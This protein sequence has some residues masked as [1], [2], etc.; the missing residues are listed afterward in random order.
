MIPSL[1]RHPRIRWRVFLLFFTAL[2]FQK[3]ISFAAHQ[4]IWLKNGQGERISPSRNSAEPYSP[5]R[6]C[7]TCHGYA[8]ITSGGHFRIGVLR[9]GAG[10]FLNRR[11][12]KTLQRISLLTPFSE[13]LASKR[14]V[15]SRTMGL[16]VY[17]W[18]GA[19]GK[20][21]PK[22][23][24]AAAAGGWYHPGGGILEFARKPDGSLDFSKPL[25]GA[26]TGKADRLDGDF[27]SRFTPDG[28]S[29]FQASGAV[30]AD[31]LICHDQDYR[32]K[33]RNTQLDRRNYR[34]A[35]TSG[36][37][38]GR[39]DGAVFNPIPLPTDAAGED[40]RKGR[41]NFET[42]PGVSYEWSDRARFT[43]EG[44]LKGKVIS[45]AVSARN[46]LQCHGEMAA[47]NMGTIF[48]AGNDV[49]V[50]AGFRCTDCHGLE[51]KTKAERLRHRFAGEEARRISGGGL[52]TCVSCH[53]EGRYRPQRAGL[54]E[55][56]KNPLKVH[57]GKFPRASFHF[58]VIG[59]AGCHITAQPA[60]GGYVVDM[61]AGAKEWYTADALR[62]TE[63]LSGLAGTAAVPW[64][65]WMTRYDSGYGEG[66]QYRPDLPLASQWFGE[67]MPDGSIQPVA[68]AHVGAAL[69]KI[70]LSSVEVVGIDGK[71]ARKRTVASPED[72]QKGLAAL[73]G[74]GFRSPVFVSERI[75]ELK[76]G[77]LN[78]ATDFKTPYAFDFII[79]HG[80]APLDKKRTYGVKGKP[81]GCLDCHAPDAAFFTKMKIV[82]PG[83]F[84]KES[85]PVPKE[86]NA[87]PQ[88]KAWGFRAVPGFQ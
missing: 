82:N 53:L 47:V 68:L 51:G 23:R 27:S 73:A 57:R 72:V 62:A 4:D 46:C 63:T 36:A 65:P 85:Y 50:R 10:P 35:A 40:V 14:N 79:H 7:G 45:G 39:I 8:T 44:K 74:L 12:L 88:M 48:D 71:R 25:A 1:Q 30:E 22:G 80:V 64:R 69:Q 19:G 86:P 34:W 9:P 59:C 16:S 56:A 43:A 87:V 52:K 84:L 6:S 5:R 37:G 33:D 29:H 15:S 77:R 78:V 3:E 13:T 42:R 83:G 31:C 20:Y 61:A 54:P 81:E 60:R 49:H 32:M 38:M 2:F 18:I 67:K 76:K 58:Y 75:Y 41:W 26:E 66:V 11:I 24:V 28:K 55:E 21:L 17:D 70:K